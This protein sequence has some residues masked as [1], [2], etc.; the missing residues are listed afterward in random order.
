MISRS[1]RDRLAWW[2]FGLSVGVNV[3]ALYWPRSVTGGG[4]PYLDKVVHIAIFA[5]VAFTGRRVGIPVT[6]LVV[7]L[8]AHAVASELVQHWWLSA[9]SGDPLDVVADLTGVALGVVAGV[10]RGSR[11]RIMAS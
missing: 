5:A 4:A 2:A 9:R 8:A 3:L 1:A 10:A 7:V 6:A 11:R